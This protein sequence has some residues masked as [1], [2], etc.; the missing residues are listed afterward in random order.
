MLEVN[1]LR[2]IRLQKFTQVDPNALVGVPAEE[3]VE[4]CEVVVTIVLVGKSFIERQQ[5][6]VVVAGEE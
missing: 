2:L 6:A 3:S 4:V 5:G 1:D